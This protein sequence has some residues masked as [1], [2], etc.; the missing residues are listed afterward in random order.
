FFL[1]GLTVGL[2]VLAI[3]YPQ[4]VSCGCISFVGLTV[5]SITAAVER[6]RGPF[7]RVTRETFDKLWSRWR[8]VHGTPKGVIERAPDPPMPKNLESDIGDYSFDRAVITD[9]AR[10]VD[11][12]VANNFHF[13]NN[14]AI[15]SIDGYPKRPFLIIKK[16]LKKNPRL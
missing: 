7:V 1:L 11:L 9:R 14:C 2:I 15:L 3:R 4:M 8:D 10:T 5:L 12:L 6:R 13:E 16:M